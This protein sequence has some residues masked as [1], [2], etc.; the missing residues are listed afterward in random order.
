LAVNPGSAY[1]EGVLQGALIDLNT[2]KGKVRNYALL[3]G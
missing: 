2:K 3:E 1:D